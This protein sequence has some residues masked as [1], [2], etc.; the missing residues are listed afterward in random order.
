MHEVS[1]CQSILNTLEQE[2]GEDQ[3][4]AVRDIHLKIGILS[5]IEPEALKHVFKYII[6]DTPFENAVLYVDMVDVKAV[7]DLC[8]NTFKVEK[9]KFICP[10]C[11]NPVSNIIEGKELLLKVE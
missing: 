4:S 2:L 1:I 3:L 6:V 11:L 5:T 8:G 10:E 7:C 9:Y